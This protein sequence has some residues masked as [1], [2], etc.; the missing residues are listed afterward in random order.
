MPAHNVFDYVWRISETAASVG[1]ISWAIRRRYGLDSELDKRGQA[2]R[3][4]IVLAC[5]L[6]CFVPGDQFWPLRV[7]SFVAS[8]VLIALPGAVIYL[9]HA[10]ERIRELI[11]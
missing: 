9:Q 6:L 11:H 10:A 1:L 3:W 4:V 7:A 8:L 2:I 5:F